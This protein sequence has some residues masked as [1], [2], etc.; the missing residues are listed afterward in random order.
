MVISFLKYQPTVVSPTQ[1]N[2][3]VIER[4]SSHKLFGLIIWYDL[5]WNELCDHVYNKALKRL[6]ALRSLRKTR[7]N[8][9]DLVRVYCTLVRSVID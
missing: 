3:A 4:V 9:D 8:C 7:L 5:T 6:Y 2:G 1:L